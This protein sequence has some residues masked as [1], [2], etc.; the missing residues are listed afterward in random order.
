MK[1]KNLRIIFG[2]TTLVFVA[3]LAVVCLYADREQNALCFWLSVGFMTLTFLLST[4]SLY[5]TDFKS[6]S[7]MAEI[8]VLP[9]FCSLAYFGASFGINTVFVVL[10]LD[11]DVFHTILNLIILI[12][13]VTCRVFIPNYLDKAAHKAEIVKQKTGNTARISKQIGALMQYAENE[14]IRIALRSLKEHVDYSDNVGSLDAAEAEE[15]IMA[16]LFELKDMLEQK[17][18]TQIILKQ[19]SEVLTLWKERSARMG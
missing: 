6:D 2:L 5:L 17:R 16:R 18:E 13:F 15:K 9:V 10:E 3:W 14:E 19:I 4:V 8:N 1:N 12:A 7:G 11:S